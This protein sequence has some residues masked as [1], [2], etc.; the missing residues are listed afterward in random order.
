MR[1]NMDTN[2]A[3]AFNTNINRG[4]YKKLLEMLGHY[5]ISVDRIT[6]NNDI[7]IIYSGKDTYCL[8]KLNDSRRETLK[9]LQLYD[10]LTEG[11]FKNL[12]AYIKTRDGK[13]FVRNNRG[14]Y[15]LSQWIEGR[16]GSYENFNDIKGFTLLLADFH[17]KSQGYYNK[18]VKSD[19][20]SSNWQSKQERYQKVF[21]IIL[22]IIKNKKIKTM[23]DL[24]YMES[25]EFFN[26]QL[27]L[28]VKLINQS[29]YN[30]L[31]Q[32]SQLKC[33]L[34][35]DNFSMKYLIAGNYEDYYLTSLDSVKYNMNIFDLSKLLKKILYRREYSWDFKFC[36]EIIEDYCTINPISRDELSILLSLLIFPQSFY[37]I[38]KKKY[39]K[40]KKCEE[41]RYITKLHKLVR[42][43]EQQKAF[44]D[45]FIEYYSISVKE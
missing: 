28:S 42:F 15:Y 3:G 30:K 25:I 33:S 21:N 34:C 17:L 10:Y 8:R 19:Y 40:N 5:N 37:K 45:E 9:N 32:S 23:F 11:G 16:K 43:K 1:V 27:E 36:R 13:R 24:M 29:N 2:S 38:G 39:I 7:F 22:N 26:S 44:T 14:S 41:S 20:K 12:P 4:E 18:H 31:M 35:L 6:G